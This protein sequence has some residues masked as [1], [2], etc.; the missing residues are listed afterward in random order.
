MGDTPDATTTLLVY[1]AKNANNEKFTEDIIKAGDK[2]VVKAKLV[3]YKG[4]TPETSGAR[5][6]C[7]LRRDP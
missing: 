1:R 2:I 7:G 3:N 5:R 6:N 4:N